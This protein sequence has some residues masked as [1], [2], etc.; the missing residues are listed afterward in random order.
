MTLQ[1]YKIYKIYKQIYLTGTANGIPT[2]PKLNALPKSYI[3]KSD[4]REK[5]RDNIQQKKKLLNKDS[6]IKIIRTLWTRNYSN[7]TRKQNSIDR[8]IAIMD[9][10]VFK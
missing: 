5:W 9:I 7:Q 3:S 2:N 4:Q 8:I 10:I 6:H 1:N